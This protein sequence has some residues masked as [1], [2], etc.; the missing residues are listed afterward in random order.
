[1][2]LA[3]KR[4]LVGRSGSSVQLDPKPGIEFAMYWNIK[5]ATT[6]KSVAGPT[7]NAE[8]APLDVAATPGNG[9]RE[10]EESGRQT[11][12]GGIDGGH[13]GKTILRRGCRCRNDGRPHR[14]DLLSNPLSELVVQ[15]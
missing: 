8:R 10:Q 6:I 7:N 5:N 3:A 13:V 1:V 11:D 4:T 12:N 15:H 14:L 2:R 9:P